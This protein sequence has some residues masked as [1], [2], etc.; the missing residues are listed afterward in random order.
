MKSTMNW[1]LD[2]VIDLIVHFIEYDQD[3]KQM[4]YEVAWHLVQRY[5]GGSVTFSLNS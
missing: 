3:L 5:H 1:K 4:S 2:T